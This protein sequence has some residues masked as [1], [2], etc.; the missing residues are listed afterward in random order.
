MRTMVFSKASAVQQETAGH[1]CTCLIMCV[2][3]HAYLRNLPE[4]SLVSNNGHIESRIKVPERGPWS[5]HE[6]HFEARV[7]PVEKQGKGSREKISFA[8]LKTKHAAL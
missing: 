7:W 3:L 2:N 6:V 4:I 8:K 1:V 5:Q